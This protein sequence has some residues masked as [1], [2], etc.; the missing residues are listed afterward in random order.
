M[1]GKPSRME[2]IMTATVLTGLGNTPWM[3]GT[4]FGTEPVP[5]EQVEHLLSFDVHEAPLELITPDGF[6]SDH[7]RK[8]VYRTDTGKVLGVHGSGYPLIPF[9]ET[10]I[11]DTRKILGDERLVVST[12]GTLR[13]GAVGWV[14]VVPPQAR[15]V[16][17]VSY[18]PTLTATTSHD[19]SLARVWKRTVTVIVC[20]NTHTA[21]MGE[22]TPEFRA[23]K[24]SGARDITDRIPDA[25]QALGLVASTADAFEASVLELLGRPVSP[26]R[27]DRWLSEYN[28]VPQPKSVDK[29]GRAYTL[30]VNRRDALQAMWR[31]DERVAPWA[32]T[33]WG[34]AQLVNTYAHHVAP[35]RGAGRSERNMERTLTGK[36]G[37]VAEGALRVLARV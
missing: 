5:F 23:R 18:W 35:V 8:V 26:A 37:D 29:P 27:F 9:T 24:T 14:Q 11:A 3:D 32:G 25:Q 4:A 33:A 17:G 34:V 19:G 10:L 30:A 28:P 31:H 1:S 6:I 22:G 13:D 15:E 7:G 16:G 20:Q 2:K 21:A 36:W 12:A